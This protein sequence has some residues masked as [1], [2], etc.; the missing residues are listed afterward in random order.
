MIKIIKLLPLEVIRLKI[1]KYL[2]KVRRKPQIVTY[3]YTL[4]GQDTQ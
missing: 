2:I 3:K 4:V 1:T